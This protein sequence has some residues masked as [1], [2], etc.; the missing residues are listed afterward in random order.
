MRFLLFLTV[1]I[2]GLFVY[3]AIPSPSVIPPT[4]NVAPV[5]QPFLTQAILGEM[6]MNMQN[7]A[8]ARDYYL[9]LAVKTNDPVIAKRAVYLAIATETPEKATGSAI[10]WADYQPD[11]LSAQQ[12]AANLLL[13]E[14]R[15]KEA[16]PYIMRLVSTA[17]ADSGDM[18]RFTSAIDVPDA[19][20]PEAAPWQELLQFF[21]VLT[22]QFNDNPQALYNIASFFQEKKVN[23]PGLNAID[24]ALSLKP[25][26]AQAMTLHAQIILQSEGPAKALI[27]IQDQLRK[28]PKNTTLTLIEAQL[29]V[30]E[31]QLPAAEKAFLKLR[32]DPE[33][34]PVA[35][36]HLAQVAIESGQLDKAKGYLEAAQSNP[37]VTD[38][39]T[40][41]LGS[42]AEHQSRIADAIIAYTKVGPSSYYLSAQLK[43]AVLL[44]QQGDITGARKQLHNIDINSYDDVRQV[45]IVE[46]EILLAANQPEEAMN[47]L[48]DALKI[49]PTN[50]QLLYLQ[51]L[52]AQELEKFDVAERNLKTILAIDPNQINALNT[53]GF[54]LTDHSTRYSEALTYINRA[55]KL[56]PQNPSVLDSMGWLQYRLGNA[57]SALDYL[58]KAY[59]LSPDSDIAGHLGVVLWETGDHKTATKLWESAL[60]KSPNDKNLQALIAKTK[61]GP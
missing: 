61:E 33:V 12:I 30:E 32:N 15:L 50:I 27:Y 45:Y 29:F 46:A 3:W 19:N 9:D 8:L 2:G 49:V 24:R 26:W 56:Q 43:A 20:A 10:I 44:A 42:I 11:S 7:P 23:K 13:S 31:K 28:Y 51:A 34:G 55:L 54:I 18:E 41:L 22:D 52:L 39:C 40:F 57:K 5:Q 48:G 17:P 21:G 6:A 53:L 58:Q 16:E 14:G 37:S 59:Q 47:A 35:L 60:E 1:I 25:D 36:L 38:A 4:L